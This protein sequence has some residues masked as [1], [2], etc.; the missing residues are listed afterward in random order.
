MEQN[1][2]LRRKAIRSIKQKQFREQTFKKLSNRVGKGNKCSL[3]NIKVIDSGRNVVKEYYD[4][5]SIEKA[6]AEYNIGH[7]RQ[8][9][10]SKAYKDRI[11]KKLKHDNVRDKILSRELDAEEC[12]YRDIHEFLSLLKK[13]GT[14]NENKVR[15]EI[16]E[17][18]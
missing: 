17:A 8:A 4:R 13:S 11:Y 5:K 9:F 18:E 3:K 12:D 1:Q 7:F 16:G 10:E 14:D 15:R 2:R 6:I